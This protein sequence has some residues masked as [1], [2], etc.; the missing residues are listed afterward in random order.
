MPRGPP[1]RVCRP[2]RARGCLAVLLPEHLDRKLAV[3]P[4]ALNQRC[5]VGGQVG[6]SVRLPGWR[7]HSVNLGRASRRRRQASGRARGSPSSMP[8]RHACSRAARR[9]FPTA[10][11]LPSRASA[12]PST[13][14]HDHQPLSGLLIAARWGFSNVGSQPNQIGWEPTRHM[15]ARQLFGNLHPCVCFWIDGRDSEPTHG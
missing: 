5:H 2:A 4:L 11:S 6:A 1:A 3:P 12:G 15:P 14:G 7:E 8:R 9:R 13:F 10:R